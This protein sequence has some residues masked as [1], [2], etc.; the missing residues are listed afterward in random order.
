MFC[1]SRDPEITR[2]DH[3]APLLLDSFHRQVCCYSYRFL[4]LKRVEP[5]N[6]EQNFLGH[7]NDTIHFHELK[8]SE[9][10]KTVRPPKPNNAVVVCI[11]T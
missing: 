7:S 8:H 6:P 2:E 5:S 3:D 11:K 10:L 9:E 4:L 1:N